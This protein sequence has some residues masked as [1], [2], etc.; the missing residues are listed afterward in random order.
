MAEARKCDRCHAFYELPEKQQDRD[1]HYEFKGAYVKLLFCD[2]NRDYPN[3]VRWYDLCPNC[4]E[5]LDKWLENPD[6]YDPQELVR[7]INDTKYE[8]PSPLLKETLEECGYKLSDSHEESERPSTMDKLRD[9]CENFGG[10]ECS[11][12]PFYDED[13]WDECSLKTEPCNWSEEEIFSK[14]LDYK[15]KHPDWRRK[16]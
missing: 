15:V 2:N 11:E 9:F 7:N 12:C 4:V 3:T 5:L 8:F 16:E 1:A 6:N 10:N 14:L 13:S